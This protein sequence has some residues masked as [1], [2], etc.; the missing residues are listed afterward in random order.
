LT[1]IPHLALLLCNL[2]QIQ[3][4]FLAWK[5]IVDENYEHISGGA[6]CLNLGGERERER[7]EE[8]SLDEYV[9]FDHLRFQLST[10]A[11]FGCM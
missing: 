7:S 2:W 10:D 5:L 11:D 9:E 3:R 4:S 8:L 1:S 6:E